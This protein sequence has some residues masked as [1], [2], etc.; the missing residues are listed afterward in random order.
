MGISRNEDCPPDRSRKY[1]EDMSKMAD[2]MKMSQI[3]NMSSSHMSGSLMNSSI[4]SGSQMSDSLLSSSMMNSS[5]M[6]S[7]L[8]NSSQ[9]SMSG[10]MSGS[11]YQPKSSMKRPTKKTGTPAVGFNGVKNDTEYPGKSFVESYDLIIIFY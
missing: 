1:Q 11:I 5:M 7:S 3:S 9:M 4:M 8:M 2:S 10:S 6:K